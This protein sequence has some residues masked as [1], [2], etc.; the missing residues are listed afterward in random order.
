MSFFEKNPYLFLSF[1]PFILHLIA[2]VLMFALIKDGILPFRNPDTLS[3][4]G[5]WR[6]YDL[7]LMPLF[8]LFGLICLALAFKKKED[9]KEKREEK[10]EEKKEKDG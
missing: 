5:L 8:S 9:R 3:I 1:S 7:I 2:S 6:I 10:R 4:D